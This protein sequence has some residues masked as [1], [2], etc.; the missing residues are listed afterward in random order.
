MPLEDPRDLAELARL[1]A[2]DL[3]REN[4][5]TVRE[6]LL[7]PLLRLLGYSFGTVNSILHEKSLNL[8]T[9][10]QRIGRKRVDL[11]YIPTCRMKHFWI[12]EA[13]PGKDGDIDSGDLLQ[14]YLY[15]T[16][17]EIQARLYVL[18]NGCTLEV[19][20]VRALEWDKPVLHLSISD[21]ADRWVE[22]ERLL[23]ASHLLNSQYAT[24]Q[25]DLDKILQVEVSE[26]RATL[27]Q[28]QLILTIE[29]AKPNIRK[30]GDR[31][32]VENV[33]E[34]ADANR[35]EWAAVS[36]E[37]LLAQMRAA[38]LV[39]STP[40]LDA[41][42]THCRAS[43]SNIEVLRQN[44]WGRP[45]MAFR[46]AYLGTLARLLES[47]AKD[48][49]APMI[50]DVATEN[51]MHWARYKL[52]ATLIRLEHT[53]MRIF[54]K[55]MAQR[56]YTDAKAVLG[57]W[58][59]RYYREGLFEAISMLGLDRRGRAQVAMIVPAV[60]YLYNRLS[61]NHQQGLDDSISAL[62]ALEADFV[63]RIFDAKLLPGIVSWAPETE[64]GA[65]KSVLVAGTMTMLG[66]EPHLAARPDL[67]TAIS[68]AVGA[69]PQPTAGPTEAARLREI[70]SM[71]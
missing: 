66:T 28:Q 13:K 5:Q 16:H 53:I 70:L 59:D 38:V 29:Q 30:N 67:R 18:C 71:M 46:M 56:G 9:P 15:A 19:Y 7:A 41:V 1:A 2:L 50:V 39:P 27:N 68:E 20:D 44:A 48:V 24:L 45:R 8:A 55:L 49:V 42:A 6:V 51:L 32:W 61:R 54:C 3:S 52:Q 23:A 36:F 10:F 22:V 47:E 57:S 37:D 25:A 26:D 63:D 17:P 34:T 43:L 69:Y 12:I 14:A 35:R 64:L 62:E 11:D 60:Q 65:K 31:L 21:L 4:E 58:G 33:Q 40:L